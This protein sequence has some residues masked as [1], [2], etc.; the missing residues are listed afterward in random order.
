MRQTLRISH[1]ICQF[2]RDQ[3]LHYN[4][5]VHAKIITRK[6]H[7][8][9][10]IL[11][12]VGHRLHFIPDLLCGHWGE[13]FSQQSVHCACDRSFWIQPGG[14]LDHANVVNHHQCTC[15]LKMKSEPFKD[16]K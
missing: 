5:F 8:K 11:L 16:E 1:T 10:K 7:V 12:W 15:H 13:R 4:H 2:T 6:N 9:S 14:F 3:N